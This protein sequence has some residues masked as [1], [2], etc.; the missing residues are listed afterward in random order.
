MAKILVVEDNADNLDVIRF[1]LLQRGHQVLTAFSG[2]EGLSAALNSQPELIVLDLAMPNMDGWH[3]ARALRRDPATQHIPILV[4]TA[5][6]QSED[7]LRAYEAGVDDYI[8]KP[9]DVDAFFAAV[10]SLLVRQKYT[11]K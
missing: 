1:L 2:V 3:A 9:I 4:V 10:A 6:A 11:Q 7:R 5:R 8:T